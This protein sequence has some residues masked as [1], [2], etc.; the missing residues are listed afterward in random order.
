MISSRIS[1]L[2]EA[3]VTA[4]KAEVAGLWGADLTEDTGNEAQSLRVRDCGSV[5]ARTGGVAASLGTKA[6]RHSHHRSFPQSGEYL[7]SGGI[8][9]CREPADDGCVQQ[10]SDV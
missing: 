7:A 5:V 2:R 6:R 1:V 10:P 3:R 4:G 9:E 8:D